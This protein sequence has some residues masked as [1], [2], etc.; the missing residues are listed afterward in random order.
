MTIWK[1]HLHTLVGF[2][3]VLL[4]NPLE[5]CSRGADT[6]SCF[7][8]FLLTF[9]LSTGF[10]GKVYPQ[11]YLFYVCGD[12]RNIVS[13]LFVLWLKSAAMIAAEMRHASTN[14]T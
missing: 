4:H 3:R 10:E 5:T 7:F 1:D 14:T 8:M 2:E 11:I 12:G 6:L 13:S 9:V